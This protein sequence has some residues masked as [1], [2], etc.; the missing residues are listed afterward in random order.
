MADDLEDLTTARRV[1]METRL[2]WAKTISAGYK[3]GDTETAIKNIIE[4]QQ[5]I[6]VIDVAMQELEDAE[7]L[8]DDD[9]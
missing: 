3:R 2:N 1:L 4:V 9:E 5:A 8:E 7:E 6:E